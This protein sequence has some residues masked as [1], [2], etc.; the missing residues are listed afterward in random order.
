M[1]LDDWITIGDNEVFTSQFW[2][3]RTFDKSMCEPISSGDCPL[4]A[5]L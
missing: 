3:Q 1:D 5:G 4:L 2:I